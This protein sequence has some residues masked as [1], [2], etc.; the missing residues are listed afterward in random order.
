MQGLIIKDTQIFPSPVPGYREGKVRSRRY[1]CEQM[2]PWWKLK[3]SKAFGAGN[4]S[5]K[6]EPLFAGLG[7]GGNRPDEG[8]KTVGGF[9]RSQR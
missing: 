2:R 5:G 4:G 3:Q 9:V 1:R 6:D 7:E 8:V